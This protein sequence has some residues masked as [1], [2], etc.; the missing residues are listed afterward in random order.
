MHYISGRWI[1]KGKNNISS[2]ERTIW[3]I[4][5]NNYIDFVCL[6][7]RNKIIQEYDVDGDGKLNDNELINYIQVC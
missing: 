2:T 5:R 4:R 6:D 1:E 3:R 7:F